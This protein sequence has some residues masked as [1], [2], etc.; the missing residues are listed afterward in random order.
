VRAADAAGL[1]GRDATQP[2]VL[3]ARPEAP[4]PNRPTPG[5]R[6]TSDSVTF[7][8]TRNPQ[9][10]AYRLQIAQSL[11]TTGGTGG[12]ADFSKP[13]ADRTELENNELTLSLPLGSYQWRVASLRGSAQSPDIGPWSDSQTVLR[14]APPPP[15]PVVPGAPKTQEPAAVDG[16]MLLRWTETPGASYRVQIARDP[17]FSQ[18][19][20][21]EAVSQAQWLFTKPPGGTYYIRVSTTSSDG[22]AGPFGDTQ[23]IDVANN[24]P[25]WLLLLPALI[26]LL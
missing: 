19:V 10:R 16:G 13:L 1:E 24:R 21:N 7:G 22:M 2:F 25:W 23:V 3:K 8:W 9:A 6:V 20:V 17:A 11:S 15:P 18:L 14:E 4:F 5:A 26:L 12:T